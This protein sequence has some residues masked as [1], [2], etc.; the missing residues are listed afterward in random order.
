MFWLALAG[1]IL[2]ACVPP[3]Q[4]GSGPGGRNGRKKKRGIAAFQAHFAAT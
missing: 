1:G 4:G 2:R 3:G